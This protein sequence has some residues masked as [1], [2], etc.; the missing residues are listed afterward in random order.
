MTT[1]LLAY[2]KGE[3]NQYLLLPK[4]SDTIIF[5][6]IKPQ[7][8]IRDDR[9]ST[10]TSIQNKMETRV[11]TSFA[12]WWGSSMCYKNNLKKRLSKFERRS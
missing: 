1:L 6:K 8:K 9:W 7:I 4:T 12:P 10:L 11:H 2:L 3:K 5:N